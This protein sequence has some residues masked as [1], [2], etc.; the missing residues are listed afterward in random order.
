MEKHAGGRPPKY[1]DPE[2]LKQKVDEYFDQCIPEYLKDAE[3]IIKTTDKHQP[4]VINL[5][6][7]SSVG[8][9]LYLGYMNRQSLYD[10]EKNDK[11]SCIIKEARSKVEQWVYQHTIDGTVPPAV[12]IFILKQFG[13]TDRQQI[14]INKTNPIFDML[15]ELTGRDA[16]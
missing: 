13:Y 14:D 3:G 7:P 2:V 10:N 12:G 4:I 5:N 9:A 6:S 15:Q 11:F 16:K 8:L 1:T